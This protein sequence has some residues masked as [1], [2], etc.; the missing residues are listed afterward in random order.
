HIQYY[1]SM[2]EIKGCLRANGV[3]AAY[4]SDFMT[5]LCAY[6]A[7]LW[8]AGQGSEKRRT[9]K[10]KLRSPTGTIRDITRQMP[11]TNTS[12]GRRSDQKIGKE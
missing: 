8:S 2:K 11:T 4:P 9:I 12:A 1:R 6:K 5:T 3:L 10:Q 7:R